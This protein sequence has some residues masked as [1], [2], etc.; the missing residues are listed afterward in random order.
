VKWHEVTAV[1]GGTFDPPHLGHQAA[2]QGLFKNPG[3]KRALILP[4]PAPP[5]KTLASSSEDRIEMTRRC[6][7]PHL[8][9]GPVSVDLRELKLLKAQT[10][11][12]DPSYTFNTLQDIRREIQDVAFV[13]GT[14]QLEKLPTWYRFPEL[15][16]LCHWIVLLRKPNHNDGKAHKI[17][18]EWS[19]SGL[20]SHISDT[21]WATQSG[22][23]SLKIAETDAP[24]LSSTQIREA[25]ARTGLPPENSLP[26]EVISYLK[27]RG[28]YGTK[29]AH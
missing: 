3:I 26:S 29:P 17:L 15:L 4:S 1:F 7:A 11:A 2:V 25:I 28:I 10:G 27:L 8:F 20:L 22:K 18:S 19:A 21:Q 14:D 23:F 13:I 16:E 9:A 6:F 12:P 24:E 5:H